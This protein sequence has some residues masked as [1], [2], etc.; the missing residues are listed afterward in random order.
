M[1]GT[2]GLLYTPESTMRRLLIVFLSNIKQN[3]HH[4]QKPGYLQL[5]RPCNH[6]NLHVK[7]TQIATEK[8]SL[9]QHD[10]NTSIN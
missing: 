5:H 6:Q 7:A 9:K 2:K 3:L 8:L 10:K 4:G 1:T